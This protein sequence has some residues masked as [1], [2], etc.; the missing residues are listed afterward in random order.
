VEKGYTYSSLEN[1]EAPDL[2]AKLNPGLTIPNHLSLSC[3][4]C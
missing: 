2:N 1:N 3:C 4:V